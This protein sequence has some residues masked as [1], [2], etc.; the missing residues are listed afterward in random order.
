MY[1]LYQLYDVGRAMMA[2]MRA[3]AQTAQ[4]VFQ[5]PFLPTSYSGFGRVVAAGAELVERVTRRFDKPSFGL[6]HTSINGKPVAITEAVL[7][8]KPFCRLL[9]FQRDTAVVQPKILVVA[10][11]AGHHATLL[12]GTIEAL[13]PEHDV[14]VTDWLDARQ[15][16]LSQGK[17]DLDDYVSYLLEFIR[18]LGPD[19]HLIAVCQPVVP[20]MIAVSV[21]AQLQD[22]AQ[23]RS[24]TLMGGPVDP[25][26]A[27]TQV[28]ELAEK[29][30]LAWFKNAVTTSV[31]L[32]YPGALREVYPGFMQ[33]TGFIS[34][35]ME[36]H[37]GEYVQLF[38]NLVRGDGDSAARHREFYDEYLSVMDITAEFYLQ[39][40]ERVFQQ[41]LL[42]KGK[43]VWNDMRIDPAH[44]TKT[45]LLTVE[46]ELDDIS[47]PGQT[48]AAHALCKGLPAGM[49]QQLLQKGVGHYGIFNGR[50][51]RE[52]IVPVIRGFISKHDAAPQPKAAKPTVGKPAAVKPAAK[53]LAKATPLQRRRTLR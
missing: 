43:Y 36:R 4:T 33:L 12:R 15:V 2:P 26:T 38:K 48:L 16:P 34:M 9:H 21:L 5:N 44:I 24:M 11:M 51:Y 25:H 22:P 52:L 17:F 6:T 53:K 28:T 46:G 50:K 8:T 31:P 14:C 29:H 45:A 30:P 39:T 1:N 13:L 18:L 27:K 23:P 40:V 42:P 19:V 3:S 49:K 37:V 7:L 10:P 20:T 41:H 35:N 32:Y 47:A